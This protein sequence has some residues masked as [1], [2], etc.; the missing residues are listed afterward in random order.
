MISSQIKM[1]F[2]QK[3]AKFESTFENIN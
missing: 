3:L 1:H 2:E